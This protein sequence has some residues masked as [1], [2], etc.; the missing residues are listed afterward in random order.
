KMKLQEDIVSPGDG[1]TP[2]LV[3]AFKNQLFWQNVA[4]QV[5]GGLKDESAV[6]PL[7]KV[8]LDPAKADIQAT[9]ALALVKI[10]KPAVTRTIKVLQDQDADLAAY[11]AA[12]V[13]KATGA[14]E[15]PKDKPHIATAGIVLGLMGRPETVEPM[16]GAIKAAKDDGTRA[17]LAREIA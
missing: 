6:E 7:L 3:E 2:G 1:K 13:Q 10:G 8:M 16:I 9:A 15:L 11:S 12:R 14:K 4:A 5:L 17:V